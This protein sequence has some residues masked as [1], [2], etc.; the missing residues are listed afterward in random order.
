MQA[1]RWGFALTVLL[2]AVFLLGGALAAQ[3]RPNYTVALQA[4]PPGPVATEAEVASA[5]R[6]WSQTAHA[7]TYDEG[8]GANTTCARCK[9]PTNWDPAQDA[10]AQQAL[11]CGSCKRVPGAPR[12]QLEGGVPVPE[13]EWQNISC[14][15]CHVP[16]GDSFERDIA[17]WN[18]QLGQYEPVENAM[19][20]CAKCHEGQHGFEVIEEQEHSTAHNAWECTVCH[21]PHSA[22]SSC[23]DCHQPGSGA[24]AMEHARH[25][26]VNCTACHDKG[27][28]SIWQDPEPTSTHSGQFITRR[29]AH[30]LTSWP[31]HNLS[32]EIDCVRCHHP[33][34]SR[35]SSVVP[36]VGCQECH[37]NGAVSLWCEY[38]MRNPD[39]NEV[40][41][42]LYE[43]P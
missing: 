9:S 1:R 13:P 4:T 33:L 22:P 7:D 34:S 35:S 8:L 2:L 24:G 29:F 12:P 37:E 3:A 17:F 14:E 15:V 5:R 28:L 36:L 26:A 16:V 39:P 32:R 43:H 30:T 23:T 20:L 19:A 38:F 25:P 10:A 41:S 11:D 31:S 21:G 42:N 6:E 40:A 18:Q 27:R